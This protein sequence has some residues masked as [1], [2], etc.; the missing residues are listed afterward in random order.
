MTDA[1]ELLEI[2]AQAARE[3]VTE[4]DLSNKGFTKIPNEISQLFNL[5]TLNFS[6]NKITEIPA[7]IGQ[8]VSLGSLEF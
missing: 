6:G 5:K 4:L 8:L 3:G 2:I 1:A 7:F